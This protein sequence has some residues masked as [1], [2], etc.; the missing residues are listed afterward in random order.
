MDAAVL[1][2]SPSSKDR[3]RRHGRVYKARDSRLE[4]LVAIKLRPEFRLT[5]ADR[6]A[7]LILEA[8]AASALN[9]ITI[10]EISDDP[11]LTTS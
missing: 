11:E 5:D 1:G 10:H 3:R 6:R 9:I 8:K 2:T 7:R 4:R